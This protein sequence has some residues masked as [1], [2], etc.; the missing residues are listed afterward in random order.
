MKIIYGTSNQE[1][2]NQVKE[3]LEYKQE[4]IEI[5]SLKEISFNEEIDENGK[6]FE[7]NSD[8][9]YGKGCCS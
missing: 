1:K 3:Y 9:R 4:D 5:L 2:I 8:N 7:E 6:T